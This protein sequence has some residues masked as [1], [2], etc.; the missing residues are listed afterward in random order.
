VYKKTFLYFNKNYL[1]FFLSFSLS[2]SL[3]HTH[4][5]ATHHARL[6]RRLQLAALQLAPVDGCEEGMAVDFL[7]AVLAAA[8]ALWHGLGHKL[9]W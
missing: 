7:G 2:L 9:Q 1:S 3:S 8:K 6:E 4:H 5:L